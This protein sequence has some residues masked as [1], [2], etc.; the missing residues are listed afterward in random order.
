M[1]A[2]T[3]NNNANTNCNP[4]PNINTS[5][6]NRKPIIS[7][8]NMHTLNKQQQD[9][10]THTQA[11]NITVSMFAIYTRFL[12]DSAK[13]YSRSRFNSCKIAK[14]SPVRGLTVAF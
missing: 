7:E 6:K 3:T 1:P 13:C 11:C 12:D 4:N 9:A 2:T 14:I 8:H 5:P 10:S